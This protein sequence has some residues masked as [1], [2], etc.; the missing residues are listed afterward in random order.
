MFDKDTVHIR[1]FA[2]KDEVKKIE[3]IYGD[4]FLWMPVDDSLDEWTQVKDTTDSVM[5]LEYQ[6]DMYDHFFIALKPQYKRVKYAFIINDQYLFGCRETTDIIKNP[7][8]KKNLFNHFNFPYLNEEDLFNAPSW[9]EDQV[10]YSIFPERFSNGDETINPEGTLEW[11]KTNKYSN[12]QFFGG[13]IQGIINNLEYLK[14][15]GFTGIYMTPIFEADASHKYDTIN[16][17][18]IDK[19]FGSNELFGKLVTEAHKLGIKVML[20]AVFNHSGFRQSILLR[21]CKKW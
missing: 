6:T 4:P 12:S 5:K 19:A 20:D 3:V 14:E 9:V 13:D 21:C 10:W 15:T 1:L 7:E 16:Y 11:G 18:K 17:F 8:A 2:K